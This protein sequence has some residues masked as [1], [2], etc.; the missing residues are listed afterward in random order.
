M[1]KRFGFVFALVDGV[2]ITLFA[3][4]YVRP[5]MPQVALVLVAA[6]YVVL[7]AV[8]VTGCIWVILWLRKTHLQ[9]QVVYP[10]QHGAW[11]KHGTQMV[12]LPA[13]TQS[14]N[15]QEIRKFTN[16][17]TPAAAVNLLPE[18]SQSLDVP[19]AP[20]FKDIEAEI[21]KDSM[22]LGYDGY[23]EPV[24]GT[25]LDLLSTN[26]VGKPGRGKSTALYFFT[27]QLMRIGAIVQIFDPHGALA[28]LAKAT[29]Y[30]H[31][32]DRMSAC[33]NYIRKE[34]TLRK[35]RYV[36]NGS[37]CFDRHYLLIVDEMP[38]IASWERNQNK[39][40]NKSVNSILALIED[41][42]LQ[43]RKFNMYVM[44]SG[45]GMP[46]TVLP[47]LTRDSL[48]SHFVFYTTDRHAQLAGLDKDVAKALL[49]RIR[50][51]GPGVCELDAAPREPELVATPSTTLE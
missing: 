31:D 51:A 29:I 30:E 46:A 49:P 9:A 24:L 21:T 40:G 32:Y 33:V 26:V 20:I 42:V 22:I 36:D 34:M 38:A 10:S 27:A 45:Q 47:T 35:R 2:I 14:L 4:F 3:L 17:V 43:G 15:V 41:I 8:L 50:I 11:I 23:G 16:T 39:L 13:I 18:L 6:F 5:F 1:L 48:S 25:I 12:P 19:V 44:V 28:S 37:K 7:T